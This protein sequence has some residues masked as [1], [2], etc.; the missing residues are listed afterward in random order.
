MSERTHSLPRAKIEKSYFTWFLW[1]LPLAAAGLCAWFILHDFIFSGPTITIYF[2]NADGLQE[3]NSM[4]IYRGIKIGDVERLK[5]AH[6]RKEVAVTV[7]LDEFA[8]DIARQNSQFWIVRPEIKLGAISGLRTIVSGNYVTVEPGGGEKTNTFIGLENPPVEPVKAIEFTLLSDDLDSLQKQSPI[9]YRGVQVGEILDFRLG[10]SSRHVV[11]SARIKQ[12][13]APLVRTNSVFW[14]AGGINI[15]AGIIN[16]LQISAESA[17]TLI[18]GGVAFATPPDYGPAVT[19]G[20]VFVLNEKE[21]DEWKKWN[22][23]IPLP[24]SPSGENAKTSLPEINS[25]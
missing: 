22:P 16:G 2:K 19:N 13:Y 12:E 11:I 4:I 24:V 10:P 8:S 23:D 15:H 5:L 18:S 3:K 9:Y 17:Q 1:A 25:H 6:D 14:N 21:N 7:K 20:A